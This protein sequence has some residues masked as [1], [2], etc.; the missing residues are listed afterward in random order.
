MINPADDEKRSRVVIRP[1]QG[2]DKNLVRTVGFWHQGKDA[3]RLQ[4][5]SDGFRRPFSRSTFKSS[6][7]GGFS[8]TLGDLCVSPNP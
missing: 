5:S 7:L 2:G 4:N 1:R 6:L 8:L 3:H